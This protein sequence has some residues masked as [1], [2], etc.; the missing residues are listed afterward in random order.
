MSMSQ[1]VVQRTSGDINWEQVIR[2]FGH[3]YDME[4][5]ESVQWIANRTS[6]QVACEVLGVALSPSLASR[7]TTADLNILQSLGDFLWVRGYTVPRLMEYHRL[8]YVWGGQTEMGFTLSREEY[9]KER[10]AGKSKNKIAREQ[11]ISGP[12]LFHWLHKWGL[13]DPAVERQEIARVTNLTFNAMNVSEPDQTGDKTAP[14]LRQN[15]TAADG[16]PRTKLQVI[17][18]STRGMGLSLAFPDQARI[19]PFEPGVN[20]ALSEHTN[21]GGIT[22]HA[23]P[24]TSVKSQVKEHDQAIPERTLLQGQAANPDPSLARAAKALPSVS[25]QLN[26]LLKPLEL[27]ETVHVMALSRDQ[28]MQTALGLMQAAI[29]QAYGD[30]T[31]L[32]GEGSA[33]GQ[34]QRYVE[35]QLSQFLKQAPLGPVTQA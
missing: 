19:Q 7:Y 24:A 8:Q 29:G 20:K 10:A 31:Q 26:L 3:Q 27:P 2:G 25:V 35:Y 14:A 9:L 4:F 18:D 15:S 5:N 22:M 17:P 13:K 6:L 12:A 11:G 33:A 21:T 34:V 23:D 16:L 32:L 28:L 1:E 30:L